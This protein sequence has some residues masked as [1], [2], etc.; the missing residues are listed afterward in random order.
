M[1]LWIVFKQTKSRAVD[2]EGK[3]NITYHISNA[4]NVDVHEHPLDDNFNINTLKNVGL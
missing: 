2:K 3:L 1:M 4:I